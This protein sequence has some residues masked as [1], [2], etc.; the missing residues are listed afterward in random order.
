MTAPRKEIRKHFLC[1]RGEKTKECYSLL[2]HLILVIPNV[3][4]RRVVLI[5]CLRIRFVSSIL[6]HAQNKRGRWDT[7]QELDDRASGM[8]MSQPYKNRGGCLK[9]NWLKT[10]FNWNCYRT[11]STFVFWKIYWNIS[12]NDSNP[13]SER[14]VGKRLFWCFGKIAKSDHYLRH[15]GQSVSPHETHWLLFEG[16]SL[17][18]IFSIFLKCAEEIQVSLKSDKNIG[19][20]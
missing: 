18:F 4:F 10:F 2:Y 5:P 1:S 14:I 12:G 9:E 16:F 11:I 15:I 20:F 8:V 3:V 13:S 19:Y 6:S 17:N 7:I